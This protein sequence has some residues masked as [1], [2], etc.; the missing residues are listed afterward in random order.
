MGNEEFEPAVDE[1]NEETGGAPE[2]VSD[3]A[4]V[5]K[6]FGKALSEYPGAPSVIEVPFSYEK[7]SRV[8]DIP[9][10]EV[11]TEKQILQAVNA[12]RSAAARAVEVNKALAAY[13]I[14]APALSDAEKAENGM[15]KALTLMGTPEDEARQMVKAMLAN[16]P[17]GRS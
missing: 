17:K 10:D 13:D 11:L 4:T 15:V 9:K 14:K 7:L 6:A 3:S 12:K 5:R 2:T 16:T 8:S 1:T